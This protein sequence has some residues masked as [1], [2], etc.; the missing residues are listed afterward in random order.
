MTIISKANIL[1]VDDSPYVLNLTSKILEDD[2]HIIIADN[3]RDALHLAHSSSPDLILLDIM[4]SEMDGYEICRRLKAS[5]NTKNIPII[6]LTAVVNEEDQVLGLNLGA[7]DYITKPFSASILKAR[8]KNSIERKK[9]EELYKKGEEKLRLIT[10][11]M[12]DYI[13]KVDVNG[14]FQFLSSS[15][16]E[17]TGFDPQK[18]IG[19]SIFHSIHP[20]DEEVLRKIFKETVA[21]KESNSHIY[22]V[23]NYQNK[24][25]CLESTLNFVLNDE[26]EVVNLISSSRDITARKNAEDALKASEAQLS[27][28]VNNINDAIF[29]L[30]IHARYTYI[31]P[32][33]LKILGRGEE[34]LGRKALEFI[35]PDDLESTKKAIRKS[36]QTGKNLKHICRYLHPEKGYIWIE[37]IGSRQILDGGSLK[38]IHASRDINDRKIAEQELEYKNIQLRAKNVQLLAIEEDLRNQYERLLD[39]QNALKKSEEQYRNLVENIRDIIIEVDSMGNI[40]FVSNKIE[41]LLGYKANEIKEKNIFTFIHKDDKKSLLDNYT[42]ISTI[43]KKASSDYRVLSANGEY[44]W[45]RVR[46]MAIMEGEKFCGARGVLMDIQEQKVIEDEI[47]Y[48]SFHD[49]LTGLYNRRFFEEELSRLDIKRNLP[50][51]LLMCDVNGLK[52]TND[53]FG[54]FIGDK[55]LKKAAEVLKHTCRAD[56]IIARIGGDEF[57]IL[58]PNTDTFTTEIIIQRLNASM[59]IEKVDNISLSISFGFASKILPE[60]NINEVFKQA[61]YLMYRQKLSESNDFRNKTL[62]I[63]LKSLYE[64]NEREELHAKRVSELSVSIGKALD[65]S[66]E[67]LNELNTLGLMHDIGKIT[68]ADEIL[69]S[70]NILNDISWEEIKRHTET[71]YRILSSVNEFAQLAEYIL[72][73]HERWDGEGYPKGL[74]GTAIPLPAR[75]IAI[76]DAYES[77]TSDRPF[78]KAFTNEYALMEIKNNAGKQFDPVICEVF[79][80]KVL[81]C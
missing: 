70:P 10:D 34:V 15:Y 22:R 35:H 18:L 79:I 24:Y 63:I 13:A 72:A 53:A 46:S 36:Y 45:Y 69:N 44:R 78:R 11:N 23:K 37:T 14:I 67:D 77:M 48:L 57:V 4:M 12:S 43:R 17:I 47:S 5:D 25:I 42:N 20:D 51:T 33:Y 27:F 40:V 1:I 16:F 65:L 28:V 19:K 56:D 62:R 2:Y 74:K 75:I 55:L 50:I 54:H 59:L 41:E 68:I 30:D 9:I 66:I 8:I 3:G 60:Q 64:K 80:S 52:L 81:E 61:E 6:F 32:S 7:V 49:H 38:A 26:G 21:K 73:H 29:E 71:G 58:L 31:S 76:A 39:M